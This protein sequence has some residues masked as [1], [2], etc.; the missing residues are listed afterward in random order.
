MVRRPDWSSI[1]IKNRAGLATECKG[2]VGALGSIYLCTIS[3]FFGDVLG[4]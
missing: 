1:K 3:L 2:N 4:S